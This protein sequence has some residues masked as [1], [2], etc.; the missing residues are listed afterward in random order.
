MIDWQQR[1]RARTH[2]L[3]KQGY[4]LLAENVT[5]ERAVQLTRSKAWPVGTIWFWAIME[6][7]SPT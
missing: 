4:I 7:W 5:Q 3:E 2:E 6:A 1:Q